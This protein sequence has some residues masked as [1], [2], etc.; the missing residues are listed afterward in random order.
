M[1]SDWT[2]RLRDWGIG[3]TVGVLVMVLLM[4]LVDGCV[5]V[6]PWAPQPKSLPRECAGTFVYPD[7][8]G[9]CVPKEM[10]Q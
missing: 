3:Y 1:R 10:T 2:E 7:S 9:H 6:R 5:L 4:L 8:A